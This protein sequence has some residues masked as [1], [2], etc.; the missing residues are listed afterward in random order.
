MNGEIIDLCEVVPVGEVRFGRSTRR[1]S[2]G[3]QV[4]LSEPRQTGVAV[5]ELARNT[6]E[7]EAARHDGRAAA[8]AARFEET[9]RRL[10]SVSS[11]DVAV[12]LYE[13]FLSHGR[14][15]REA[16]L[17]A[18]GRDVSESELRRA[19]DAKEVALSE[20]AR[21]DPASAAGVDARI[22]EAFRD[23]GLSESAAKRA[24]R[25]R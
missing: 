11:V 14:G 10:S 19:L 7:I 21:T 24:T 17:M 8:A 3:N 23:L 9:R 15:E 1:T 13:T 16:F 4:S 20:S 18:M 6:A 25:G 2:P 5:D 12:D 22:E